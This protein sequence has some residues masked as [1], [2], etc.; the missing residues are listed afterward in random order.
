MMRRNTFFCLARLNHEGV[1]CQENRAY[2]SRLELGLVVSLTICTVVFV[3]SRRTHPSLVFP[4]Y[5]VG[6]A[7]TALDLPPVTRSGGMHR[8]PTL[9]QV[10]MPSEDEQIPEE[11]TIELTDLDLSLGVPTLEGLGLGEVGS[12]G[13]GGGIPRPLRLALPEYPEAL[14][15][16]GVEG[17][18][19]LSMR[20]NSRGQVDSV[21]VVENS[22]GNRR[23]AQ[24]AVEAAKK[25][26]YMPAK[27]GEN[28]RSLWITRPYTFEG[29]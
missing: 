29:K 20:I 21:Y 8:I 14:R 22:S 15:K 26:L 11:E 12:L 3:T 4:E 1:H 2:K 23:L 24:S 5:V 19:V 7:L 28:R 6:E 17:V 16:N 27:P 13:G 9:P 18:V 25:T 10:P